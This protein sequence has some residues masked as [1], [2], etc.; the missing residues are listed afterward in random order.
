MR[1]EKNDPQIIFPWGER[2]FRPGWYE[3][4][5][6]FKEPV[7]GQVQFFFDMGFGFNEIEAVTLHPIEDHI[8]F[9][10]IIKLPSKPKALRVDP[11]DQ[12]IEFELE[13]IFGKRIPI[14][15]LIGFGV[16]RVFTAVR[17]NPSLFP[18][19]VKRA[20]I[21]LRGNSVAGLRIATS[22]QDTAEASYLAWMK[23]FDFLPSRDAEQYRQRIARLA[24]NPKISLVVPVYNTP[25]EH[26]KKMLNSVLEQIY[27]NWELCIAD[28][29][30]PYSNVAKILHSYSKRDP[31]IKVVFR[32]ENGHVCAASN[33]AL[34]C[35]T[36]DWIALLD[37]D[38]ELR[39]H[40]LAE[41]AIAID[42]N[43]D[44]EMIYSDEDKID[45][46]S[47]TRFDPFFKPDFSRELLR[48]MNYFN[49]LTVHRTEN[50][51]AVGGWREGYE[52][53]QDYDLILRILD[54]INPENICHIPKI[55][56]HWRATD[57][58]TA[59]AVS[60]KDYAF[61][62]G[63]RALKDHLDRNILNATVS[64]AG[65]LPF[66]KVNYALPVQQPMISLIIPT[67]DKVDVLKN[68]ISSI[69][70]LTA[71]E[72]YEILIVDNGSVERATQQYFSQ[73]QTNSKK[74][75]V[76]RWDKPFNFS[77]INNAAVQATSG[78]IL[79]FINNDIEVKNADW[80]SEM[81]SL[82]TLNDVGCVGAKLYYSDGTIQHGGVITG[83][84]GVAGHAHKYYPGDAHGYFGRLGVVQN[85]SAVTA[86]CLLIRRY[87][88]EKV[89]GFD[90]ELKVA[91][92][93]VDFCLRVREAGYKNV[94]TPFA[95][96]TH[97]E[98]KSRG[99]EDTPEKIARFQREI[100]YMQSKWGKV[101]SNDPY[102]NPNL[103]RTHEDFSF[104]S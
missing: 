8:F 46:L 69:L 11:S 30:S 95:E 99:E 38:D 82:L 48:S 26:L 56:Y 43:P 72:N 100:R 103:S 97:F 93:D 71:Y 55:L 35:V 36:G 27:E 96:L 49:H 86:A 21:L 81:A 57:G 4:F 17:Q 45:T 44:C 98:S 12:N 3:F 52:G 25:T 7:S 29:A 102:Y 92:N 94:W 73:L 24:C 78:E 63:M 90:E 60:E 16:S 83:I 37:H 19:L 23:R 51:R 74:V 59:K 76:M 28:D 54:K 58:S 61:D 34:D 64:Q 15:K 87:V 39:P 80:L 42:D 67:R 1:G 2:S 5:I 70:S 62:A 104:R 53:S 32:R 18:Y 9:K 40:S 47:E 31:R 66:Y 75:R 91:F 41:I 33:S 101:L 88:F 68:A 14:H 79:G 65:N 10:G 89:G 77:E 84:G 85:F 22:E 6:R 13:E 20:L 50:V